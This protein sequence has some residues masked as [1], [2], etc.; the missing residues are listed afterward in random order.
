[1]INNFMCEDCD[2]AAVCKVLD[3]LAKFKDSAKNPLGVDITIDSCI[4]FDVDEED[5]A[6]A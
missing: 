3:I 1:M 6:D 5:T 4:N 2:K